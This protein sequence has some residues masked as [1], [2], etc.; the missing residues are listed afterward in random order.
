M[1]NAIIVGCGISGAT[2]ANILANN[3]WKVT[4][5]EKQ[6]H[7]GGNCYDSYDKNGILIHNYGPHIFH[8]SDEE[9]YNFISKFTKLNGYVNKVLVNVDNKL[10]P[11]PINFDSIKIIMGNKGK[12]VINKLLKLFPNQKT[13][14][15]YDLRKIND[16]L[17]KEFVDYISKNVYYNYSSKMWGKKF[18]E[19]DPDTISRVKIV[20]GYEHNYFPDDKYQGLPILGYTDMIK[21]MVDHPNITIH[22]NTNALY[23]LKF[24]SNKILLNGKELID[25]LIYCGPL[26]EVLNYQYGMLPYRSLDILFETIGQNSYQETAVINYPADP[27]MT[28]IAEYKKMT[29]QTKKTNTTISKEYPGQF[30]LNSNKFNVRYYPIINEINNDIYNKYLCFFKKYNNFFTLGRL[31][32]YKYFDMDDAIKE[33]IKLS[34]FLTNYKK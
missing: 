17:V 22:L 20:L 14:T 28:R 33:A 8:T 10:F 27:Y 29:L 24:E 15:L 31:S 3:G 26:D 25:P 1:K 2:I 6:D 30:N 19:I 4:V 32:Q 18:E 21:R 11:L 34:L 12:L 16:S 13:V 7:I 5:Y 23:L 9:V